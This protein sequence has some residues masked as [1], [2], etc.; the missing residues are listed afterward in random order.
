VLDLRWEAPVSRA[1]LTAIG[2]ESFG[3]RQN[4]ARSPADRSIAALRAAVAASRPLIIWSAGQAGREMLSLLRQVGC[5]ATAFVDRDPR[6]QGQLVDGLDVRD[7]RTLD[8]AGPVRPFV[9]V[10][11]I[12]G[13]E[14]SDSLET[15]GYIN[16]TDYVIV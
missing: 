5:P 14:I 8:D 16:E 3:S 13:Q 4:D 2:V 11:G 6:K 1:M 7:P 12:F 10:C 15:R 9:A